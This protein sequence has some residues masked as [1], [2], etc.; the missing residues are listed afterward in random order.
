MAPRVTGLRAKVRSLTLFACISTNPTMTCAIGAGAV[1]AGLPGS[2]SPEAELAIA[3]FGQFRNRLHDALSGC[4]SARELI[5]RGFSRDV[6]VAATYDTS[7][8]VP[9]FMGDRFVDGAAVPLG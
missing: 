2:R 6:E 7:A 5:A 4:G 8:V 3:V 9:F 1:L